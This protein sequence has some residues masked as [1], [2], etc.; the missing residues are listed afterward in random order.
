MQAAP[1]EGSLDAGLRKT[2]RRR[3]DGRPQGPLG[4]KGENPKMQEGSF[5]SSRL[6][7]WP[8]GLNTSVTV[9]NLKIKKT[10]PPT[11]CRAPQ[12]LPPSSLQLPDA[13]LCP[14]SLRS[15]LAASVHRAASGHEAW[16][17][18]RGLAPPRPIF[19]SLRPAPTFHLN[20]RVTPWTPSPI[21]AEAPVTG[22]TAECPSGSGPRHPCAW[23][24]V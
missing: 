24:A 15:L 5:P 12:G 21:L 14:L 16:H 10:L 1:C 2:H 18:A 20:G 9:F 6:V 23:L 22:H 7:A 8:R 13:V 3:R 17:S 19:A 11:A 4:S